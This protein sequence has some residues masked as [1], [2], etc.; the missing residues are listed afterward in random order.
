MR[1]AAEGSD[2]AVD[3]QKAAL[4]KTLQHITNLKADE[5]EKLKDPVIVTMEVETLDEILE[6]YREIL[7]KMPFL[8]HLRWPKMNG[9]KSWMN[10]DC[11]KLCKMGE[12]YI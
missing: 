4:K 3:Q 5:G 6:K 11:L 9:N 1:R 2:D 10:H 8:C 7:R 12:M